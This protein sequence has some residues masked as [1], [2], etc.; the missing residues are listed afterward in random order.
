[1]KDNY[2]VPAGMKFLIGCVVN[3]D[4]RVLISGVIGSRSSSR[5]CSNS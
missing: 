3:S 1:M 5:Y 4:G 2:L